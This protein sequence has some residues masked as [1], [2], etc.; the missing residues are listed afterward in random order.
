[1]PN[2]KRTADIAVCVIAQT[3]K[4]ELTYP[5]CIG[6]VLGKKEAGSCNEQTYE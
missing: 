4:D 3:P 2:M 6:E 5:V 1:M